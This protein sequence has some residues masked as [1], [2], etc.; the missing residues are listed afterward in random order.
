M[1]RV[2]SSRGNEIIYREDKFVKGKKLSSLISYDL[3][4]KEIFGFR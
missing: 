4:A 2:F 3:I 1:I